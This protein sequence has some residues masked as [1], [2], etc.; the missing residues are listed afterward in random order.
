MSRGFTNCEAMLRAALTAGYAVPQFNVNGLEWSKA[1]L[2][3][4]EE[5]QSPVI[6]GT[7]MGAVDAMGG[8][9]TVVAAIKGLLEDLNITVPV[10]LHL[11]HGNYEASMTCIREG[12][13]SIMFDGSK[14]SFED[15]L[16]KTAVLSELCKKHQISLEAEVG[17]VGSTNQGLVNSGECADPA[18][19]G[20]IAKQ[21]I[22]MLAAGIGNIHGVYPSNWVGL[23]WDVLSA[24]K[25]EIKDIPL[26]LHGGSG[27][28]EIMLKRAISMG[29]AKININ[30]ECQLAF[31][32]GARAYFDE[33]RDKEEKGYF[34]R[35][36][37][38][39]GTNAM[40]LVVRD[41]IMLF[42]C[43]GKA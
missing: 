27:I 28:P 15:N 18:E 21:G 5:M 23:N 19:C 6:L 41:K 16:Q 20:E 36:L 9:R 30:T 32:D 10:A 7:A 43:E 38:L 13:S 37:I 14:L 34:I 31:M 33:G 17:T 22:T 11:D 39:A 40:K 2:E 3:V 24:I 42:G 8:Y 25:K 12:Y 29:V 26:V 4:C 1:V 35:K